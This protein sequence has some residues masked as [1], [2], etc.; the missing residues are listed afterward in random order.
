MKESEVGRQACPVARCLGVV[1]DRWTLMI[2]RDAFGGV[3]RF[4]GFVGQCGASRA[5]VASR[6]KLLV[7]EKVMQPVAYQQ[8]PPRYD[9]RLTRKGRDLNGTMR[10]LASWGEKW[11]GRRPAGPGK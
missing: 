9:Y 6:L 3:T 4:E 8:N 1:G 10:A 7:R 11:A 5:I 2:L